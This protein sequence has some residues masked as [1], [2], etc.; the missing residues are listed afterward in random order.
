[1]D[2]DAASESLLA[3]RARVE[4]DLENLR[5]PG[6]GHGGDTADRLDV[7]QDDAV[8]T[9]ADELDEGMIEELEASLEEIDE[10]LARVREG[11]YGICVGC[12]A[13]IPESR[14]AAL[15]ATARCI[16]CQRREEHR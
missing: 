14:L 9:Y 8:T 16:D 5:A 1:M 2:I 11:T 6:G 15:P 4:R 13:A 7:G 10:A 3:E 12:G